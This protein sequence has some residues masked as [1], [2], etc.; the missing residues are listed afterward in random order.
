MGNARSRLAATNCTTSRDATWSTPGLPIKRG[1]FSKFYLACVDRVEPK[2]VLH[3]VAQALQRQ[4]GND[5]GQS[6]D[7]ALVDPQIERRLHELLA[8]A[9]EHATL[10][11]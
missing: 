7:E 8:I 1:H 3:L 2:P 11:H 9:H 6:L 5:V 10:T 4:R